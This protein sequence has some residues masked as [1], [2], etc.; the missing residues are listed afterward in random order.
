[1]PKATR[2]E[3]IE[4]AATAHTD[5]NMFAV[6]DDLLDGSHVSAEAYDDVQI[7]IRL[8][9]RAQDRCMRRYDAAI[10]ASLKG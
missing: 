7:I 5:L 3:H 2:K 8:A 10:A 9:R 4:A 1:M 6:I